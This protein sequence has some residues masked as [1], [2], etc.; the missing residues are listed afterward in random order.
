H[1]DSQQDLLVAAGQIARTAAQAPADSV[2]LQY[3]SGAPATGDLILSFQ[4][5]RD[6]AGT[7]FEDPNTFEPLYQGYTVFYLDGGSRRVLQ[8]FLPAPPS[9]T[10]APA[11]PAAVLGVLNPAADKAVAHQVDSF[12]ALDPSD[13]SPTDVVTNPLRFRLQ[14]GQAKRDQ[15]VSLE[16]VRSVRLYR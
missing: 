14:V 6:A 12:M 3:P 10:I 8:A 13:D 2:L 11:A 4:T 5:A 16:A 9:T 7:Y 15:M 1:Q